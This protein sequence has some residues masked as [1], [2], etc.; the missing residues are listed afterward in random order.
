MSKIKNIFGGLTFAVVFLAGNLFCQTNHLP[1]ATPRQ[2]LQSKIE[3]VKPT[4]IT[5]T[6]TIVVKPE[7]ETLNILRQATENKWFKPDMILGG[8][9]A[10]LAGIIAGVVIQL[11]EKRRRVKDENEF[12]EKILRAIFYELETLGK[13][14]EDGMGKYQKELEQSETLSVRLSLT[15]DWFTIFHNNSVHLGKIDSKVSR[16]IILAY[17]ETK[18]LIEDLKINNDYISNV[19]QIESQLRF[20]P[21]DVYLVEK[22]KL[23]I[24]WMA[25]QFARIK[26]DYSKCKSAVVELKTLLAKRG[27][28]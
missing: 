20:A 17:A 28:S 4:L 24:K 26:E 1:T 13:M 21:H 15:Q 19:D 25:T 6:N 9:I 23:Y 14:Y 11:L 2:V 27:I 16:Q 10:A 3:I 18:R 22:R 8:F 5:L 7:Q 12:E